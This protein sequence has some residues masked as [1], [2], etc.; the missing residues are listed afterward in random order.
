VKTVTDLAQKYNLD[1]I[2]FE[3]VLLS[4]CHFIYLVIFMFFFSWEYPGIQGIGCNDVNPDDTTNFLSFLQEM[5][6]HP[7]G[8]NL[9]LS[10]ATADVP[11]IG[12]DGEPS[13]DVSQFSKVL[14]YIGIMNYDIWGPWTPTVGPNAPLNDSCAI[15]SD[16][17]GSAVS[18]VKTWNDAGIPLNQIVLSVPAYGH[19]FRVYTANAFEDAAHTTL[20]LY[21]PFDAANQPAGDKWDDTAGVDVCGNTTG[22]GGLWDFWGMIQAGYLNADG[23]VAS[24]MAYRFDQC[25]QTVSHIAEQFPLVLTCTILFKAFSL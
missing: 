14:D 18:G 22:V 20:A 2:D 17:L 3:Y 19:S 4:F 6:Q 9:I 25:S 12:P 10:A 23:T 13:A 24:G 7:L 5:R 11:F 21:P 16:Q 8:Q 1:G 15:P